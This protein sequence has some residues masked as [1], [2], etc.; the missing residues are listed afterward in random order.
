MDIPM[1]K[2]CM[3]KTYTN[4]VLVTSTGRRMKGTLSKQPCTLLD[5]LCSTSP[6]PALGT[7]SLPSGQKSIPGVTTYPSFEGAGLLREGGELRSRGG[8]SVMA[9]QQGQGHLCGAEPLRRLH[10]GGRV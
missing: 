7:H 10:Q 4:L 5:E 3:Q 8:R 6:V 9:N 2:K 1:C